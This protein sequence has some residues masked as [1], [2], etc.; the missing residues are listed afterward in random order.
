MEGF[1]HNQSGCENLKREDSMMMGTYL[2]ALVLG[3]MLLLKVCEKPCK[4]TMKFIGF[5]VVI[6]SFVAVFCSGYKLVKYRL[7]SCPHHKYGYHHKKHKD[8]KGM[9]KKS[10]NPEEHH[11]ED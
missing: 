5:F 4:K 7:Y 10:E 3:A 1:L 8:R 6:L 11:S 9:D 2:I